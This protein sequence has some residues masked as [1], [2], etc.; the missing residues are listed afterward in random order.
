MKKEK[1]MGVR[2]IGKKLE[3]ILLP[4]SGYIIYISSEMKNTFAMYGGNSVI[5]FAGLILTIA[6]SILHITA[7]VQMLRA[8]GQK[9]LETKGMFGMVRHPMYSTMI[10]L[11]IPG[12]AIMLNTWLLLTSSVIMLI[13]FYIMIK[14]EDEFLENLFGN[15]FKEYKQHVGK[16]L[17]RITLKRR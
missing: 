17:P 13:L 7:A 4:Y 15:E 11:I 16:L 8:F 9:K 1:K 5:F 12:L 14:E 3:L 6:G 10:F 2:G